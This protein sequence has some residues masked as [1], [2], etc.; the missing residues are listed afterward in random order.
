MRFLP[1]L[2][3]LLLLPA[4]PARVSATPPAGPVHAA[5]TGVVALPLAAR[6]GRSRGFGRRPSTGIRRTTG[7]PP[8]ARRFFG[9]VLRFLGI[10][11]L[12]NLLFGLGPGGASPLGLLLV[13]GLIVLFATRG[14]RRR[15]RHAA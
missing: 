1:L 6:F 9:G 7:R 14:R 2:G 5:P 4:A 8:S 11:Y 10:A 12:F 3:V 15:M 13:L